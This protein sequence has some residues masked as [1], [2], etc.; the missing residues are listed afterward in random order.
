MPRALRILLALFV[1]L[2]AVVVLF[3][4]IGWRRLTRGL[5]TAAQIRATPPPAGSQPLGF[6]S[7]PQPMIDAVTTAED[8]D[9]F[10]HHG[11][12]YLELTRAAVTQRP[13]SSTI[14]RQLAWWLEPGNR[15]AM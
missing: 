3:G 13:A 2:A 5:P 10:L 8:E 9:F 7:I 1:A 6:S 14:T 4:W 15:K 11:I 12:N